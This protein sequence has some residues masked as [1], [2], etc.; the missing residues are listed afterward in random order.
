[1]LALTRKCFETT[2]IGD[3]IF[4]T[5]LSIGKGP[6]P[7]I[8]LGIESPAEITVSLIDIEENSDNE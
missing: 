1:M 6:N 7:E 4:I 2:L 8:Q 3:D 5:V